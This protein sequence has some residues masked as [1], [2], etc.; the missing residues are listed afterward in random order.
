MKLQKYGMQLKLTIP[1]NPEA[2][3]KNERDYLPILHALVKTCKGKANL[4][5]RLLPFICGLIEPLIVQLLVI[6]LSSLCMD[7]NP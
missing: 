3:G 4:W 6:C 7:T 5:L 2:N 1:Y